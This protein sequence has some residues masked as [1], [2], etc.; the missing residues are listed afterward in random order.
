MNNE[1][2][3]EYLNEI[4]LKKLERSL[5]KYNML[6]YK[7]LLFY[8]YPNLKEGK[9]DGKIIE[10]NKEAGRT[11]YELELPADEIF[12]KIH[13]HISVIYTVNEK[14][15]VIILETLNPE[16]L[17]LEGSKNELTTY[18]GILISKTS[19]EKDIY[20]I[21]L[22]N[23]L[24][25]NSHK[26]YDEIKSIPSANTKSVKKV[27][28]ETETK[29][30]KETTIKESN[31]EQTKNNETKTLK[32]KIKTAWIIYLMLTTLIA[33]ISLIIKIYE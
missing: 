28:K 29:D 7:K 9:F 17:L 24:S 2:I 26:S 14:E 25:N 33:L 27:I 6:A 10:Q 3:I 12:K 21:N 23:L 1:Y 16:N 30:N 4:K 5:R 31:I 8:Y 22:L 11:K 20:K 19:R 18:K 13:G 32:E 15:K